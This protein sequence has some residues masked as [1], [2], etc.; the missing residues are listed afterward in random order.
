LPFQGVDN[1]YSVLL[2]SNNG[3]VMEKPIHVLSKDSEAIRFLYAAQGIEEGEKLLYKSDS[4]PT[5]FEVMRIEEAPEKYT[6]F[7]DPSAVIFR[8]AATGKTCVINFQ[9][10]EPNKYYYYTFRTIDKGGMSNPTEVFKVRMVSY[11]NGIFMELEPYEMFI[12]PKEFKLS[13]GRNIKISPALNQ[14]TI[15][16]SQVIER[17]GQEAEENPTALSK[18]RKELGLKTP[19][20]TKEFQKSAPTKEEITLGNAPEDKRVWDKRFK[21][22]CT[23]KITGKKIDINVTFKQKKDTILRPS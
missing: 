12:K 7:D 6:D 2:Q 22:R 10:I 16:F 9:D 20:D 14:K 21:I 8:R 19:V 17:I 5:H 18:I 13:F 15:N 1:E 4:L 3:E 11:Q 23:S